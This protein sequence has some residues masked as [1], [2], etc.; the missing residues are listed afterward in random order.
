MK[1]ARSLL[2]E[3]L[4]ARVLSLHARAP[5][6]EEM[7]NVL[8]EDERPLHSRPGAGEELAWLNEHLSLLTA[9]QRQVLFLWLEHGPQKA[10]EL[11]GIS[12]GCVCQYVRAA[13]SKLRRARDGEPVQRYPDRWKE[14][15][16]A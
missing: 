1:R 9:R 3:R 2:G 13:L 11:A 15:V 12:E 5:S 8:A 4:R 6:G 7:A 10:G 16:R 14:D